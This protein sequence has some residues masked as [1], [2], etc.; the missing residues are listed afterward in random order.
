[1]PFFDPPSRF[2][3]SY[4][5]LKIIINTTI[6][7]VGFDYAIAL[8]AQGALLK[9]CSAFPKAKSRQESELLKGKIEYYDG[10]QIVYLILKKI[11]GTTSTF[12]FVGHLSK[13]FLDWNTSRRISGAHACLLH[14]GAGLIT[15]RACKKAG[16]PS[17]TLVHHSHIEE[18]QELLK[19]E[20]RLGNVPF[21]PLSCRAQVERQLQEF[22]ETDLIVCPSNCVRNSF[23]RAGISSEK[24]LTIPHG[25][26]LQMP[27]L[28]NWSKKCDSKTLVVLFVGQLH[29]RKGLRYLF[30]AL[31]ILSDPDIE[32]RIVG[33]DFGEYELPDNLSISTVS[34]VGVKKG[35][36]LVSEYRKADVF[37]LPSVEEGFG[38]VVLEA[39]A[40]QLPVIVSEAVGAIDFIQDGKQ[41]FVVPTRDPAA[42]AQKLSILK[43]DPAL[44]QLMGERAHQT[45]QDLAD[46]QASARI[47]VESIKDFKRQ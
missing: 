42:I 33:P 16:I 5:A 44:R 19:E 22:E 21:S 40:M 3:D 35:Q 29:Y 28:D 25:V 15:I 6:K 20:A 8:D 46:W 17:I 27:K 26:S 45:A 12:R 11:I 23:L 41:G 2:Q 38:L 18:Q 31:T 13:I 37:V 10:I 32:L 9:L 39:M 47:L 1:M 36:D 24:L 43:N 7:P 4:F 30:Q 34:K 14:S